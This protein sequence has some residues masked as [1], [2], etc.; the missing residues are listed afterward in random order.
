MQSESAAPAENRSQRFHPPYT[1]TWRRR[2]WGC[3][4]LWWRLQTW[5]IEQTHPRLTGQQLIAADSATRIAPRQTRGVRE[6]TRQQ[7]PHR[8]HSMISEAVPGCVARCYPASPLQPFISLAKSVFLISR[9]AV[10]RISFNLNSPKAVRCG[11]SQSLLR[12]PW[13][14]QV[15]IQ[16]A[17][18]VR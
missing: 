10:K 18:Q 4:S 8:P 3:W 7:A 6:R 12:D 9:D 13:P 1:S 14:I 15:S 2:H 5:T 16:A 17:L 11:R